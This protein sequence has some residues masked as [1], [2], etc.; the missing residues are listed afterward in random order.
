MNSSLP[1]PSLSLE[2][3]AN[4][5][6]E[7]GYCLLG[8]ALTDD[9]LKSLRKRLTEQALAEKQQGF[10]FQDGGHSQNWGDFRDSAGVL[11]P[12]E[13]TEAQGGR[14]Q[15]VWTLVNK[16]AVFLDLL[17]H[18]AIRELVTGLLGDH[19]LLS[20]HTANIANPSGVAMRLHTDQWWM[21]PPTRIGRAGLPAGSMSRELFDKDTESTG[22]ISPP[23]VLNILWML[24]EFT[25]SNG[26]TR[27]VPGSH[28]SG[29]QPDST[30]KSI[31]A[32]GPAG[33][34]LLCDGRI[35]HGTGANSSD[36]PRRAVLT[37][38]CTP[39]FR[40]QENY[41]VGTRQEVLDT[42]NPDLLEL[43]G[44]RIWHAYG[45]TGH[46]TDDYIA[47]DNSPLGELIPD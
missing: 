5:L 18:T 40:P 38:F 43:L 12:Q 27:V 46:P 47:R 15:R 8:D 3:C 20:S 32:T 19:Y 26:G 34:A 16:G 23:V 29:C 11:R 14:N 33:T 36:R 25:K 28:L 22:T 42:A 35:W 45:R 13:F 30:T 9:Q 21:P 24:D 41:T 4:D 10:A 37:T 17:S 1:Q 39:Q 6:A 7:Q 2:Q 31:A 44:F